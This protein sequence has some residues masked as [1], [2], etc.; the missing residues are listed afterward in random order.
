MPLAIVLSAPWVRVLSCEDIAREI[1]TNL[2]FL[3]VSSAASGERINSMRAVFDYSWSMLDE[4]E[5]RALRRFSVFR[6]GFDRQAAA[7]VAGA[8][9]EN[10]A[11]LVDQ[12]LLVNVSEQRYDCHDLLRQYMFEKLVEA[13]EMESIVGRHLLYF[14]DMAELKER[15]LG[16]PEALRAF[17]WLIREQP[18]LLAAMQSALSRNSSDADQMAHRLGALLHQDWHRYGIQHLRGAG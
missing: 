11:S 13:G 1:Q 3:A 9:L 12:S 17:A 2:D 16:S 6:G 14:S 10:L 5:Q 8:T 18:N 15:Q 4:A 7:E